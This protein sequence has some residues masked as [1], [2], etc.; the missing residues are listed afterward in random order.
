MLKVVGFP[1]S[2]HYRKFGYKPRPVRAFTINGLML[3]EIDISLQVACSDQLWDQDVC[4]FVTDLGIWLDLWLIYGL[5]FRAAVGTQ[6]QHLSACV[7]AV[8]ACMR[9]RV[10]ELSRACSA[11]LLY[12][13]ASCYFLL[14]QHRPELAAEK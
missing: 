3:I 1:T 6:T 9:A 7:C 14:D 2:S 12:V 8:G 4:L 5:C 10:K 13:R 11:T